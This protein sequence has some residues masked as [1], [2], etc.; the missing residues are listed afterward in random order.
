MCQTAPSWP[1]TKTSSRPSWFFPID[2]RSV[3]R[4]LL[5]GLPRLFHSLQF[6]AT[7]PGFRLASLSLLVV[8]GHCCAPLASGSGQIAQQKSTLWIGINPNRAVTTVWRTKPGT[9][10]S[11]GLNYRTT[12][13]TAYFA[14]CRFLQSA[15]GG[16]RTEFLF[17][18]GD[19]MKSI[20]FPSESTARYKYA[21]LPAT[22]TYVSS[23]RQERFGL[24]ISQRI[25]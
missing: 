23:T 6:G 21:H 9:M 12:D 10:L 17:R 5:G 13:T 3:C 8:V 11:I 22:R 16:H 15:P 18:I 1:T 25:R 14:A 19:S 24:R 4:I 20:V 2:N 7:H